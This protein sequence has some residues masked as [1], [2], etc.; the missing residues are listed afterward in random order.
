MQTQSSDVESSL[1]EISAANQAKRRRLASTHSSLSQ[2]SQSGL[3][4]GDS[5][6]SLRRQLTSLAARQKTLLQC[7]KTQK[8]VVKKLEALSHRLTGEAVAFPYSSEPGAGDSAQKR[9]PSAA[10]PNL[11]KHLKPQQNTSNSEAR[12]EQLSAVQQ[13]SAVQPSR[14]R[15]STVVGPTM[16][17]HKH[18]PP[19]STT[20]K[21]GGM[22]ALIS[23]L[24]YYLIP[25]YGQSLIL[26]QGRGKQLLSLRQDNWEI[27]PQSV[28]SLPK[29][30]P[31]PHFKLR[32]WLC[33]VTQHL[34]IHTD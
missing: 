26:A 29:L 7:F 13:R 19:N 8:E 27:L 28:S 31:S 11:L 10:I 21:T 34:H 22:S 5:S 33:V 17:E 24:P 18:P 12:L 14:V 1:R 16:A 20:T 9:G 25:M 2:H 6:E 30:T 23:P 15:A 3:S 4:V 32:W